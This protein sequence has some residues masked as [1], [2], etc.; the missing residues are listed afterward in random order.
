MAKKKIIRRKNKNSL[1][2]IKYIPVL[3]II[4]VFFYILS[5]GEVDFSSAMSPFNILSENACAK[6]CHDTGYMGWYCYQDYCLSGD[7]NAENGGQ[8]CSGGKQCCCS[9]SENIPT[10]L[11]PQPSQVVTG[12]SDDCDVYC[13]TT[14]GVAGVCMEEDSECCIGYPT[15]EKYQDS[16][17]PQ[18]CEDGFSCCCAVNSGYCDN[19]CSDPDGINAFEQTITRFF[20]TDSVWLD[21]CVRM[22]IDGRVEDVAVCSPGDWSCGV[23]EYYCTEDN[24]A[25]YELIKCPERCVNGVC[26]V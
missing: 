25:A 22:Y 11:I 15:F 7:F 6:I 10:Q 24:T 13:R 8:G 9:P 23:K 2:I 19:A 17:F 4:A 3:A 16:N 21:S 26:E 1:D 5:S 14:R 20:P 18:K 12:V